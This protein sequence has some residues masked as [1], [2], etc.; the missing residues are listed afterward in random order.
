[1]TKQGRR[2][3]GAEAGSLLIVVLRKRAIIGRERK[4]SAAFRHS[5]RRRGFAIVLRQ[6]SRSR[7]EERRRGGMRSGE[8]VAGVK[9]REAFFFGPQME[10]GEQRAI[11]QRAA[12][13]RSPR[14][15]NGLSDDAKCCSFRERGKRGEK[16]N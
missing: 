4:I 16:G 12:L 15:A 1:M 2:E 9:A 8:A 7:E 11:I 5:R 14:V 10:L 3:L 6:T 13:T